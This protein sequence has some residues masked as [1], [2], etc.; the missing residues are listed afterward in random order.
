MGS[1]HV[2]SMQPDR[3]F[4]GGSSLYGCLLLLLSFW[5]V[6]GQFETVLSFA[7]LRLRCNWALSLK[8]LRARSFAR[9]IVW[10]HPPK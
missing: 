10:E 7:N 6:L 8:H 4:S 5:A 9:L 2:A 3:K 1:R